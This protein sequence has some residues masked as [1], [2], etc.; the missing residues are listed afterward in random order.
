MP[1]HTSGRTSIEA[2]KRLSGARSNAGL[3]QADVAKALLVSTETLNNWEQGR[4]E[5]RLS[6]LKTLCV[7]YGCSPS[8]L[9]LGDDH[10]LPD[11]SQVAV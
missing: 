1:R 5:P 4:S 9:I 10:A 8:F 6:D 11:T 3:T 2:A 7:L